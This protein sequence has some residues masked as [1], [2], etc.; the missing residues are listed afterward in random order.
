MSK[1]DETMFPGDYEGKVYTYVPEAVKGM[2]TGQTV[3]CEVSPCDMELVSTA[4]GTRWD[5]AESGGAV[6]VHDGVPFAVTSK[7]LAPLKA[8]AAAGH[9]V[10]VAVKRV[11]TVSRGVPDLAT[12]SAPPAEIRGWCRENGIDPRGPV[13]FAAPSGP[14][15]ERP[16]T[17][18]TSPVASDGKSLATGCIWGAAIL[19]IAAVYNFVTSIF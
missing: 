13:R 4:T 1:I 3:I 14:S 2:R 16:A 6:L 10:T 12:I 18:P 11:G 15:P 7:G 19:A 9:P 8:V 5:T 17:E